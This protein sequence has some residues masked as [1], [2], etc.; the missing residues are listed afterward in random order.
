[1]LMA[2]NIRLQGITVAS[3]R[4]QLEMVRGIEAMR[5]EPVID[6]RFALE[7]IGDA[8]RYQESGRHLGKIVLEVPGSQP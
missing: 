8:F 3:R 5:L 1:M 4:H 2:K 6:K 7:R